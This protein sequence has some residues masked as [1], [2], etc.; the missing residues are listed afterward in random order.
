MKNNAL[1]LIM[2]IGLIP[3]SHGQLSKLL[4]KEKSSEP[5]FEMEGRTPSKPSTLSMHS[6]YIGKIVFSDQQL[7]EENTIES[8]FKSSFSLDQPIYAR[9]FTANAVENYMLYSTEQGQPQGARENLRNTYTIYY[10]VDSVQVQGLY[11]YNRNGLDGV[12]SWERMV[13][14]P[15]AEDDDWQG[16]RVRD[17]MNKL[18]PGIHKVKVVIWGG[19]GEELATCKP[20]A[21]GEFDLTIGEG[22]KIKIGKNWN[23]IKNGAIAS[24][25]KIK[26]KLLELTNA[27]MK[28]N[29]PDVTVKEHKIVS[30][31]YGIQKDEYNYPKFRFVQV[32]TYA[33]GNKSGKCF[34]IYT[35]YA[36][37]YAG[38]GTY[39]SNFYKWIDMVNEIDCE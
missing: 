17:L 13:N 37:D 18:E 36:Q 7:T 2:I 10:Y 28:A 29:Q 1:L 15:G 22:S 25:A 27:D 19:E 38:G 14:V 9:V 24:D 35:N 31:D 34:V 11:L 26:A 33:I 4:K 21:E 5:I 20:I 32:A 30:D 12:N 6:A 3:M 23:D 16:D 39:S 8:N